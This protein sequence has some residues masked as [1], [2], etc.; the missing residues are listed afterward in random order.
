MVREGS[1]DPC[2]CPGDLPKGMGGF[3]RAHP[4]VQEWSG[5]PPKGPGGFG[6]PTYIS[7]RGREAHPKVREGSEGPPIFPG[8][9]GRPT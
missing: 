2:G 5:G 9:V 4:E 6:R 8:G 7:R 1:V 3:G